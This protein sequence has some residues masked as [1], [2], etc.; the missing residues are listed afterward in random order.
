M[1]FDDPVAAFANV[2]RAMRPGGRLAVLVWGPMQQQ[3]WLIV[4]MAAALEHVPMAEVARSGVFSLADHDHTT[5]L[6]EAA[7]WRD[8]AI[9]PYTR[10]VLVAGGGS[11]DEALEFMSASGPGR[12]L[13]EAA[14]DQ[15]AA[16]RAVEAIRGAFQDHLTPEGVR[17]EGTALAVTATRP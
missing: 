6:L 12:A 15:A 16:D 9:Q 14:P 3:S 17:L 13:F 11:L 4:P 5:G 1:F 8:V 2:A 7:G 10:E